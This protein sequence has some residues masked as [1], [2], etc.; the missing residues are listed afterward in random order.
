VGF[1]D[2]VVI[3]LPGQFANEC[4]PIVSQGLH[5]LSVIQEARNRNGAQQEVLRSRA[6]AVHGVSPLAGF[7]LR[8]RVVVSR[9]IGG[10]LVVVRLVW[11]P[12]G[13]LRRRVRSKVGSA[14][15]G[16]SGIRDVRYNWLRDDGFWDFDPGNFN[17]SKD[18]ISKRCIVT[19]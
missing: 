17:P 7:L 10:R 16:T 12:V 11:I 8:V 3:R 1:S 9:F 15:R 4:F 6:W 19:S 13:F 5:V 18:V 14:P 2:S